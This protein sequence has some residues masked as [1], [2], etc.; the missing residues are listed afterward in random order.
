MARATSTPVYEG[1]HITRRAILCKARMETSF[2]IRGGG[3]ASVGVSLRGISLFV[4]RMLLPSFW[5][6]A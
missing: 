1:D 2:R 6:K 4:S 3:G 5:K